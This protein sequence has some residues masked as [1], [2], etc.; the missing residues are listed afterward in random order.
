LKVEPPSQKPYPCRGG[1][2]ALVYCTL[3]VTSVKGLAYVFVLV[4]VV[5]QRVFWV[6]VVVG[7]AAEDVA[8]VAVAEAVCVLDRLAAVVGVAAEDVAGATVAGAFWVADWR[9]VVVDEDDED[10]T[11]AAV[12]DWV[13][14]PVVVATRGV[15]AA[16]KMLSSAALVEDL[17]FISDKATRRTK[18]PAL[19]LNRTIFSVLLAA[20]VPVAAGVPQ[21]VPSSLT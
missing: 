6:A 9:A 15:A 16:P 17:L 13:T 19:A 10:V 12:T 20:S 5:S 1:E 3:T 4:R 14:R 18:R 21:V 2:P 11:A 8:G 7:V